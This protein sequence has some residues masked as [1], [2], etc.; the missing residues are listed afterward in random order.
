MT[1]EQKTLW[2]KLEEFQLDD[3]DS[4]FTFTD[5]LCRENGWKYEYAVRVINE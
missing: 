3:Y 4:T 5:R 1:I 2:D